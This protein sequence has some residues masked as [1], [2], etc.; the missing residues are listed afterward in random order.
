MKTILKFGQ[1][2]V[3][4]SAL[5]KEKSVNYLKVLE[6]LEKAKKQTIKREFLRSLACMNESLQGFNKIDKE[7]QKKGLS[8]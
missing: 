2:S 8:I 6:K 1:K 5:D 4:Y 3:H 7:L